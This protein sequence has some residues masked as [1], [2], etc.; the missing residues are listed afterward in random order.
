MAFRVE[1][2]REKVSSVSARI[3]IRLIVVAVHRPAE[4]IKDPAPFIVGFRAAPVLDVCRIRV[5]Y[6]DFRRD[7]GCVVL[8]VHERAN[9]VVVRRVA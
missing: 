1:I 6:D 3:G 2:F 5:P 4:I 9:V 8:R 7:I